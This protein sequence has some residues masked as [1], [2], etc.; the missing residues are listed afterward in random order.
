MPAKIFLKVLHPRQRRLLPEL[1]KFFPD[2]YLAGGAAVALL[3]G[4]RRSLDFDFFSPRE[5]DNGE[6]RNIVK[7]KLKI[8]KVI[9]DEKGEYTI[10][11]NGI[12]I[13]F[14][15]Y[16]FKIKA[17]KRIRGAILS[18]DLLT[19]AAMKAYALGRRAKWKDYADLYWIMEKR[20]SIAKIIGQ[21]KKI[22]RQEFNEKNF[23]RQLAYFKDIDYSE[24]IDWLAGFAASGRE[25]K[26]K[27]TECSLE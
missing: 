21:A 20:H 22:F 10:I 16:P 12:K 5:F 6:I 7:K 4:H 1:Q 25:I 14:L 9:R 27:L 8:K 11:V 3:L 13:T 26:R 17:A 18:P 19:L 24:K 23:R 2:F 15:C